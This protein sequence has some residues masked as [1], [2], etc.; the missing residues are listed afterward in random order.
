MKMLSAKDQVC[1]EVFSDSVKSLYPDARTWAFGSRV[2]GEIGED[3]DLDVCVVLDELDWEKR[4]RISD[5]AWEIGFE[6]D[7]LI[8]TVVFSKEQFEQG[9]SSASPL[10]KSIQDEGVTV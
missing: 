6:R 8:S 5:I 4:R 9:P 2:R 3:S 7:R 10:V 1:F